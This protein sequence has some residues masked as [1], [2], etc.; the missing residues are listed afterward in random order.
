MEAAEMAGGEHRA[1]DD[2]G[3]HDGGLWQAAEVERADLAEEHIADGDVQRAPE[4][5]DGGRREAD[6][7]RFGEWAL[8]RSPHQPGDEM[9]YGVG[10]KRATKEE[11]DVVVP[12]VHDTKALRRSESASASV[13]CS[14]AENCSAMTCAVQRKRA[15][16]LAA[17]ALRPAAVE[18]TSSL[19]P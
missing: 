3:E 14:S 1:E 5:I 13:R 8:E 10:E 9:R 18:D 17:S 12:E 16:R 2:G 6:A 7:G 4:H 11:R 15:A 19:R